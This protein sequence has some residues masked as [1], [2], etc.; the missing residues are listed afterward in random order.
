MHAQ[1]CVHETEREK[2]K[3]EWRG[4]RRQRKR[5]EIHIYRNLGFYYS[6]FPFQWSTPPLGYS[7]SLHWRHCSCLRANGFIFYF[8]SWSGSEEYR[9]CTGRHYL[10]WLS[11]PVRSMLYSYFHVVAPSSCFLS[12]WDQCN[13]QCS[14]SGRFMLMQHVC[15]CVCMC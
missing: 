12:P 15:V 14:G 13:G 1:A 6:Y 7:H 2:R 5:E 11:I 3:N 4:M 9:K 8:L 10:L